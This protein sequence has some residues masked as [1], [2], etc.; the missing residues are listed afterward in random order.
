MIN[1]ITLWIFIISAVGAVSLYLMLPR[2]DKSYKTAGALIGVAALA[3]FVV[4]GIK[5]LGA[6]KT[7]DIYFYIFSIISIVG[8]CCVIIQKRAVYSALYFVLVILSSAGLIVLLEAEFLAVALV[9]IYGGAIIVTYVFVIM[10]ANQ[11]G[12]TL[13]DQ[14][15][16]APLSACFAGFLLMATI[17]GAMTEYIHQAK[18]NESSPIAASVSNIESI[19]IT[20]MTNYVLVLEL[21]G[22]LLLVAMI[23]AIAIVS[24]RFAIDGKKDELKIGEIGKNVPPY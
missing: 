22:L 6:D 18:P 3:G 7:I 4:V 10:L 12:Q 13:Y 1:T 16:R 21:A 17:A 24:K 9:I 19:G 23:G 15:S 20:Y 2:N 11:T 8:S 14:K 5:F